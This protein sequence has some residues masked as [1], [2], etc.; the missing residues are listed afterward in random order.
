[1]DEMLAEI[2][3]AAAVLRAGGAHL[4]GVHLE[5]TPQDV[6]ECVDTL[7][8]ASGPRRFTSMCDPRL[9]PQQ[10]RRAVEA[11]AQDIVR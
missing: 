8:D 3:A 2:A 11:L 9:N 4:A 1:M 10:M 6:E 7:A 5:A